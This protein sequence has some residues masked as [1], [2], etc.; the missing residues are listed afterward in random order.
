VFVPTKGDLGTAAGLPVG[1][2]AA[3][4]VEPGDAKANIGEITKKIKELSK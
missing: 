3:A 1:T 2:S 4:V